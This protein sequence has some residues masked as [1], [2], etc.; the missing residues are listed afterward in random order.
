MKPFSAV[1]GSGDRNFERMR[2]ERSF[3]ALDT[4]P[5][6]KSYLSFDLRPSTILE[7]G[8]TTG[9]VLEKLRQISNATCTGIDISEKAIMHGREC[10]PMLD[11]KCINGETYD[12]GESNF[13]LVIFGGCLFEFDPTTLFKVFASADKS[14]KDQGHIFIWDFLS[15]GPIRR[16]YRHESETV[17]HKM[18]Y[19]NFFLASPFYRLESYKAYGLEG[20][21]DDAHYC[22]T[23]KKSSLNAFHYIDDD[24]SSIGSWSRPLR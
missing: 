8:C 13:D 1:K 2:K 14:L 11:L 23:I 12:Y 3:P 4:H 22:A 6:I 17:I 7:V 18:D 21:I 24:R 10:F 16:P 19:L 5:I 9:Y 15:I 20:P